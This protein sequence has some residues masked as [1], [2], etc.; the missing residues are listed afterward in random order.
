M[1][2]TD[3]IFFAHYQYGKCFDENDINHEKNIYHQHIDGIEN[4]ETTP[5][6]FRVTAFC[7]KRGP[8]RDYEF[9]TEAGEDI[10]EWV[11][12]M[13]DLVNSKPSS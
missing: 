8:G 11:D 9:K 13:Q 4:V 1:H 2:I 12:K 3:G 6:S 10:K 5:E 7:Q